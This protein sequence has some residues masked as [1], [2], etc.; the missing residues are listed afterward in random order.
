MKKILYTILA[1]LLFLPS[2]T[3]A[4]ATYSGTY[5][6]GLATGASAAYNNSL[7]NADILSLI[8][9]LIKAL[10]GILGVIFLILIIYAGIL[11]MTAA[12]NEDKVKKAQ[13]ILKNSVIGLVILITAY[14]ISWFVLAQIGG[15][16]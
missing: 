14:A 13:N 4:A 6:S 1:S 15:A 2:I 8:G 5:G 16:A 9:L 3:F 11:W 10:L 12:G 7:P